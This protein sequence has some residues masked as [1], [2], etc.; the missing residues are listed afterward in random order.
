MA[1]NVG[2]PNTVAVLGYGGGEWVQDWTMAETGE[3]GDMGESRR[4]EL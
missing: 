1:S 4:I 2:G 3:R